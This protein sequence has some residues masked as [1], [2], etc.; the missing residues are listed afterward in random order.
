MP[1]S[2]DTKS[3][4]TPEPLRWKRWRATLERVL[5]DAAADNWYG[6]VRLEV[7]DG[8]L[9]RILVERS[10]KDPRDVASSG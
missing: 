7:V 9:R 1:E 3:P 5:A 8:E 6:S 2:A 10:F 4:E